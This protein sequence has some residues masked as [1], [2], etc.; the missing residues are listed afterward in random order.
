MRITKATRVPFGVVFCLLVLCTSAVRAD[1]V[2]FSTLPT[3]GCFGLGCTPGANPAIDG[4]SFTGVGTGSSL[5]SGGILDIALGSFT[6]TNTASLLDPNLYLGAF[7][8]LVSFDQPVYIAGGQSTTFTATYAG[9]VTKLFGGGLLVT[10]GNAQHFSFS[11]GS[12][13][14]SFDLELKDVFLAVGGTWTGGPFTDSELLVGHV[15]NATQ[16]AAVPEPATVLL[17]GSALL[18]FAGF[19]QRLRT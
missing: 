8:A 14:G 12:Y 19:R 4:F 7:T 6:L 15:S 16:S 9:F 13:A 17:L 2:T 10:F 3:Q 5:T 11:N 1:E 18:G